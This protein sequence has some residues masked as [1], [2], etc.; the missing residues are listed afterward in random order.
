M[1]THENIIFSCLG[2]LSNTGAT[3]ALAC[4]EVVRELGLEKV[5][6]GC[7]P[8]LPLK[9]KPVIGKTKAARKLVTVDRCPFECARK[10]VEAAG[11]EITKSI[12][13]ARDIGMKKKAL[14]LDIGKGLGPQE[15]VSE[16]EA[17]RAK[18]LI[19]K[20]ILGD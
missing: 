3:S 2:G 11:F 19:E 12:V 9:V 5:A 16:E 14:H 4:L 18:G 7:L 6:F 10:T 1:P 20:I 8:S 13:L 17:K 15:H